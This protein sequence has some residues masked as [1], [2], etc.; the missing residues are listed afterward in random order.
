M[1]RR[2]FLLALSSACGELAEPSNRLSLFILRIRFLHLFLILYEK[3][4]SL[5]LPPLFRLYRLQD[6]LLLQERRPKEREGP[7]SPRTT[8]SINTESYSLTQRVIVVYFTERSKLDDLQP[9]FDKI[10]LSHKSVSLS[11]TPM[12]NELMNLS[13]RPKPLP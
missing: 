6:H 3:I 12:R 11:P 7:K 8:S 4:R 2:A 13:G 5:S 1:G 10:T 9:V